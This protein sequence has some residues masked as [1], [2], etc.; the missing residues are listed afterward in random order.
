MSDNK[1][2]LDPAA[3]FACALSLWQACQHEAEQ[4]N[5]LNLSEAYNGIDQ[6]MR[7][8]MRI[9]ELF[10]KWA[11]EHVEFDELNDVWPYVLEDKF[12]ESCIS[13]M[14]AENLDNFDGSDC[15]RVAINLR[16][17]VRLS[18]GLCISIDLTAANPIHNSPFPTFRI[19]TVRE[20][21]EDNFCEAYTLEDDPLDENF[22]PP[23]FALYGVG[24]DGLLE[25]IADRRTYAETL[26]LAQ[27]IA[28][29][30]LFPR[31]PIL[32]KIP[33]NTFPLPRTE[34]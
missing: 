22:G 5:N 17:P 8:V 29:G 6:L 33:L 25:H 9:G 30:V 31:T 11:C 27:K 3:V 2:I 32:G 13:A 7:E 1:E 12:G 23:H 4:K 10:E 28:P 18:D 19:Q 34:S 21:A 20:L 14:G 16:L 26:N 15:L 24:T